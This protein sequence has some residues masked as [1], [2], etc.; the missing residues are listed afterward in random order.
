MSNRFAIVLTLIAAP[1]AAQQPTAKPAAR[2]PRRATAVAPDTTKRDTTT[3]K[4][5]LQRFVESFNYRNL[6]PAAYSG[7]VTAIAVPAG[8]GPRPKTIYIGAAGGG[9]W[10]TANGG[11]TWRSVGD[12]LGMQAIGDIAVAPSDSNVVWAGTGERNSLRSEWWGDGVYKSTNKGV[13]WTNMGLKET[14]EIGRIAIDPKNPDVVYVAALGHLWGAGPDRGIYKTTDAGKTWTKVLFVDD[15]TG[16]VDLKIDP[17]DA[18]VLYAAAWH[19]LRWGGS[20]MEGV[21]KGS[22]IYKS[23][24]AGATWRRL[25]DPALKNGLPTEAMGRISLAVSPQNH[26]LVYAMI[27]VD[28]GVTESSQ[29]R[30]GGV[31][32]SGDAG[33]TWTQVNDLQAVPHYYYDEILV[34]PSDSNHVF[35]LFSPL[36]ESK[37]GGKTFAPDS[38]ARVHVDNHAMWIDPQDPDHWLLGN[39]GGVYLTRDRGRSWE[40]E[41]IPIGQFYTVIVDSSHTP[42]FLCGGLQDNGVWCGPSATRDREGITDADWFPVNGGDGMWVQMPPHDPW[43]VYSGWQFGN[44]SRLDLRTWK[45]DPIQPLSLDAGHDSGYEYT[46]GWTTPLLVSQFDSTTLY[47]GGNKLFKLTHRGDDWQELG[48]DMT[49]AI[50]Q[51]PAPETGNTSY[52]AIF[53]ISESPRSANILWTGTDDGYVWVTQDGGRTWANVTANF[54]RGAPTMCWVGAVVASRFADGTAYVVYDCHMRDD[55]QPHVWRTAD[56]GKTWNEIGQ[57]LPANAGS[58]TI[59]ESP[60]NPKVLWVG[61]VIGAYVTVDG[62]RRW[63]RLGK[64]LPNV[65]VEQIAMSYA[66]RDL[67][68]ATHGRGLWVLPAGPL[69]ELSDSTLIEQAHLFSVAPA[70]QYREAD[71]YPSFGSRPFT[72]ANPPRGAV[73][74]YTLKDVQPDGVKFVI[75]SAAGDT[76]RTLTGPGYAGMQRVTWDLNRDKPRPRELGAPTSPQELRRVTP[77]D[78][79]VHMTVGKVKVDQKFTVSDWPMDPQGR[80][81]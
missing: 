4:D 50:R 44:F 54:P 23:T 31:F 59:Y 80:L 75:T 81:R 43:T 46:W 41:E 61:N 58:L 22:G 76:V 53:S 36:L 65:P 64:G 7:R 45:Q 33:A 32:R 28:K 9:I 62:G 27:Q 18:T 57:G 34:D 79:V 5:S 67:V 8:Q 24:D 49:R 69:E 73:I 17:A 66:Q 39:D 21:G 74:T 51:N 14:R 72:A 71:T 11:V 26:R 70:Y 42:Y 60:R 19:R 20:H 13:A 48:P 52:H 47:A 15:T 56:F 63:L 30:W 68:L 38:L 35:L 12:G 3:V 6:G 2:P 55:Y 40:H 77:G 10:K 78:Y 25:T 1:L 29:G 37:D 16:F